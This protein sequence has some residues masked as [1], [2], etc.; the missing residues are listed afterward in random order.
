[1]PGALGLS[2]SS[3]S[4]R[5]SAVTTAPV[6]YRT[7]ATPTI[8]NTTTFAITVPA[9]VQA[10][11]Q[12]ILAL[13]WA[14]NAAPAPADPTGWSLVTVQADDEGQLA[15]RVWQRTAAGTT[16]ASSDVGTT[17][18]FTFTA[19]VK[20]TVL[21]EVYSS[22]VFSAAA[23]LVE[24]AT[25]TQ[26][27]LTPALGNDDP[28]GWLL[29]LVFDKAATP[30]TVWT[31]PAGQTLRHAGYNTG[32]AGITGALT[33]SAAPA[34]GGTVGG[35]AFVSDG[36]A[37]SRAATYSVIL[38]PGTAAP[39]NP[40]FGKH[41]FGMYN[42]CS[43][44]ASGL[45]DGQASGA[46]FAAGGD[47]A[48]NFRNI[49]NLYMDGTRVKCRRTF[50]SGMPTTD[51]T[52]N[53]AQGNVSVLSVKANV[54]GA[55]TGTSDAAFTTLAAAMPAG[56][57]LIFY[58]EPENDVAQ[59]SFTATQWVQAQ[60]HFYD[61]CKAGNPNVI[62]GQSHMAFQWGS[63][64]SSTSNP[65]LWVVGAKTDFVAV[66]AYLMEFQTGFT[67]IKDEPRFLRWFN[68]AKTLGKPLGFTELGAVRKYETNPGTGFT[69]TAPYTGDQTAAF[70]SNSVP[71]AIDNGFKFTFYWNAWH[72][73]FSGAGTTANPWHFRDMNVTTTKTEATGTV[74]PQVTGA[75]L[76]A[77]NNL[78]ATYGSTDA[79]FRNTL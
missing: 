54:P 13:G 49:V 5:R 25:A 74:G 42:A 6:A 33:D 21:L 66:D 32:A 65:D 16:G 38:K 57:Y 55:A 76:T 43:T 1:M 56:S 53:A 30:T 73:D 58:H 78:V 10:G 62:V 48:V 24:G 31:I 46:G 23:S 69:Y 8:G 28:G 36:T 11:D 61:A 3:G 35:G 52:G 26:T 2:R 14:L 39:S 44:T 7:G 64:M 79:D 41:V 51:S 68:W 34:G 63:G 70:L 22:A 18:T 45:A 19:T 75:E 77:W 9:G 15:T 47:T 67:N 27:H 4:R 71:W 29:Q 72:A 40:N 20:A 17:V 50:N 12:M 59:G 37:T 60:Q